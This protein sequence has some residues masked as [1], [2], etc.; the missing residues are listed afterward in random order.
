MEHVSHHSEEV[1]GRAVQGD[2]APEEW[3]E[4]SE[5]E[6]ENEEEWAWEG[7]QNI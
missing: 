3:T 4:D 5:F 2:N 1:D 7:N 6:I